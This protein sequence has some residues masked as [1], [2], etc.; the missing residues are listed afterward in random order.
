MFINSEGS[1]SGGPITTF[2]I[3]LKAINSL[4]TVILLSSTPY[5]PKK[6]CINISCAMF[7]LDGIC[8]KLLHFLCF[9]SSKLSFQT[10]YK[11]WELYINRECYEKREYKTFFYSISRRPV[12]GIWLR[13]WSKCVLLETLLTKSLVPES[14]WNVKYINVRSSEFKVW[15]P[16][17]ALIDLEIIYFS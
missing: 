5:S 16:S 15:T 3:G 17:F 13:S 6:K 11:K 10:K 1:L 12:C 9:P 14:N 7:S 4:A 2:M 8:R